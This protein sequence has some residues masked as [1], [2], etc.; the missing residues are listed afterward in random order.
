VRIQDRARG[1]VTI[2]KVEPGS[3]ASRAGLRRGD[4]VVGF[5]GHG[6]ARQVS[7]IHRASELISLVRSANA[8]DHALVIIE[9][10]GAKRSVRATLERMPHRLVCDTSG[11]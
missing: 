3:P 1:G 11:R 2:V 5:S 4:V 6:L 7:D 8:G 9:R 10:S